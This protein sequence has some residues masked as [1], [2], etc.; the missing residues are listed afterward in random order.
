MK[1]ERSRNR[2]GDSFGRRELFGWI[3]DSHPDERTANTLLN[4]LLPDEFFFDPIW[5][6]KGREVVRRPDCGTTGLEPQ[7]IRSI[8]RSES[9]RLIPK[10]SSFT[11]VQQK[12][13]FTA[14]RVVS[15][16]G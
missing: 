10:P 13:K 16:A 14:G 7:M 1:I 15:I 5:A 8:A 9:Q 3:N 2:R 12:G 6:L 4:V 11:G